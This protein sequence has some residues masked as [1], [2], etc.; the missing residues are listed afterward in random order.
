MIGAISIEHLMIRFV[1][2]NLILV[3]AA[4][5]QDTDEQL[6]IVFTSA[7]VA[8]QLTDGAKRGKWQFVV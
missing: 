8:R 3:A 4:D 1:L 2:N 7:A 6:V 5:S